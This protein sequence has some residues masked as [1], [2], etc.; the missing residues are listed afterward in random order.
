[1]FKSRDIL[2]L[3]SVFVVTVI[4]SNSIV[5]LINAYV[6]KFDCP[7][8]WPISIF[9]PRVPSWQ[10]MLI[11]V[12]I[13]LIFFISLRY[14]PRANFR[15]SHIIVVAIVLV[16]G[17]NLIQGW[18]NGF[19]NPI[20]G[21]GILTPITDQGIQYYHDA[22]K[23]EDPLYFLTN[24]EWLQPNLLVHS[25]THPPGAVLTIYFLFEILGKPALI[26][27]SIAVLSVFMSVFFM[28]CLIK[29]EF[30]DNCLAGY[31]AFLFILI[32]SLQIYYATSIDAL[33]ASLLLGVL[34]L[35]THPRA[36]ISIGVGCVFLF[37]ASFLTFGFLFILPVMATYEILVQRSLKKFLS[38]ILV[39]GL[40]YFILYFA[41][42]YNYVNSFLIASALENPQGFR[43]LSEPA[44]YFF[45]RL[46][47]ISEIIL[48]FGPFLCVLF[49]RGLRI[50]KKDKPNLF[51]IVIS[52]L[53]S[54]LAMFVAGTFR[55]GE[56]ARCCSFIYPYLII[57][58]ASYLQDI[59]ISLK[60]KKTLSFLVFGQAILMQVFG[61]YFW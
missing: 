42:D 29:R 35:F 51:V 20:A 50:L 31:V 2:V 45:T 1:M 28:R 14:L 4:V 56:T 46:E 55:T 60:E 8:Y 17:T 12:A 57:P 47:G 9:S 41:V 40:I 34:Y 49:I 43:L 25:R 13:L 32:P 23:I 38:T 3:A 7:S 27:I 30:G 58:V 53:F 22:I 5:R 21:G 37:F 15:M 54:L 48:F 33:I 24:Y 39:L 18:L 16:L 19:A 36:S 59:N 26:S 10:N 44:F 11:A 61:F 52:A 6:V